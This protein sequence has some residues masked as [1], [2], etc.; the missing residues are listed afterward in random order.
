MATLQELQDAFIKADDAGNTEDAQAFA[1][2]IKAMQSSAQ[3]PVAQPKS[4]FLNTDAITKP[5]PD[6]AGFLG[7]PDRSAAGERSLANVAGS[8]I[9]PAL[10]M[11]LNRSEEHTS[12]LQS[13]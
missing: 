7:L 4:Q 2:Q 12:E 9:E 1:T 5:Y 6:I 3:A 8:V 10:A 13:R 11:G